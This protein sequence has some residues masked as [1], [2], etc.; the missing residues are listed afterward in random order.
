METKIMALRVGSIAPD[1]EVEAVSGSQ[2]HKVRLSEYAKDHHVILAFYPANWTPVC[3]EEARNLSDAA[4]EFVAH[5]TKVFGISTDHIYSS[6]AWQEHAVGKLDFPLL[7]DFYPH[8]EV[9]RSYDVF[10][11]GPPLPGIPDRAAFV[12]ERGTRKIVFAKTYHL[13]EQPDVRE[14]IDALIRIEPKE[15]VRQQEAR[16]EEPRIA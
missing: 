10:R 15:E 4:P 13:G 8:G 9:C 1:F 3:T 11:T 12:I 16:Q 7:S 2:R 5:G 14:L 6:I